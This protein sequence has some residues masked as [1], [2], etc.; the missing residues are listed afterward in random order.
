MREYE[1]DF[2]KFTNFYGMFVMKIKAKVLLLKV[3]SV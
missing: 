1:C 2:L 3:D